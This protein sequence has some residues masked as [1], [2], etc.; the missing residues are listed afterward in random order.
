MNR[1]R[2]DVCLYAGLGAEVIQFVL[3][4]CFVHA[5]LLGKV[6]CSCD[7]DTENCRDF[8]LPIYI[9][10]LPLKPARCACS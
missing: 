2:D 1:M 5:C 3:C 8:T 4:S 9:Y 10:I 6:F 7:F